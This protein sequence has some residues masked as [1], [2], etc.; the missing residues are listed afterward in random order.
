MPLGKKVGLGPGHVVL[1]GDP[2]GTQPPTAAPPHFRPMPIV[3]KRSPVSVTAELL[4]K[5]KPSRSCCKTGM[6]DGYVG[7]SEVLNFG[8]PMPNSFSLRG[9]NLWCVLPHQIDWCI[10]SRL[11]GQKPQIWPTVECLGL[12]AHPLIDRSEIT[13]IT[14]NLFHNVRFHLDQ[15]IVKRLCGRNLKFGQFWN[16]VE[17]LYPRTGELIRARFSTREWTYNTLFHAK[18][19]LDRCLPM[20]KTPTFNRVFSNSAF[21]LAAQRESWTLS[22]QLQTFMCQIISKLFLNSNGLV[23]EDVRHIFAR[24][25]TGC[26]MVCRS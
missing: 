6:I 8:A 4:L 3:T 18:F 19:H 21:Q 13:H 23:I 11:W 16:I 17:L 2:V 24:G 20:G 26:S 5:F 25:A 14:V 15:C 1:D 9:V 22:A 12:H 7:L 10:A